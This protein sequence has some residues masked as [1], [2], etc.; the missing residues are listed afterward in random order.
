V[1]F[2]RDSKPAEKRFLVGLVGD[3]ESRLKVD[4]LPELAQQFRAKGVDR[5]PLQPIDPISKLLLKTL[6]NFASRLVSEGEHTNSRRI[7][8]QHLDEISNSLDE[9]VR[10]ACAGTGEDQQRL[11]A[12]LD[13]R[14]L[15][16]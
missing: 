10:L 6:S 4:T 5:S 12:R 8:A 1:H 15:R 3:A 16:I 9:A 7:G 2:R 13:G 11:R 14:T